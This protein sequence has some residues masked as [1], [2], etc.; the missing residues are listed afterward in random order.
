MGY[1]LLKG[2]GSGGSLSPG[3]G[4]EFSIGIKLADSNTTPTDEATFAG[5]LLQEEGN[6]IQTETVELKLPVGVLG[7]SSGVPTDGMAT[8]LKVWLSSSSGSNVVS[9]SNADSSNDSSVALVRTAPGGSSSSTMT[10]E[11]GVNVATVSI[12]SVTFRGFFRSQNTLGTSS[13]TL[14]L[15]SST[16]LFSDITIFTNSGTN[17]TIDHLTGTFTINVI[18]AGIDTLAKIQSTQ[19]ICRTQDSLAGVT[20]AILSVDAGV[21][22]IIGAF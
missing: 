21:F 5:T 17:T 11:L 6:A 7:D 12:S 16:G 22:E 3:F 19:L 10:S 20:P 2:G 18:A 1:Q 14:V 8:T 4:D 9:P 13:T 15:R